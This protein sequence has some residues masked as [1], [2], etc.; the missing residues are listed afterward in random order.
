LKN[1]NLDMPS[2]TLWLLD[3]SRVPEEDVA[4]F[5]QQL[6]P[7]EVRRYGRF[8]RRQRKRQFLLGRMLLRF[9]ASNLISLPLDALAIIERESNAPQLVLPNVHYLQPA[10]SISHSR[11]WVACV[12]SPN[13]S[14][15]VDIEVN[16]PTRDVLGISQLVFHSDDH[17]WLLQQIDSV[18][19]SAFYHLWCTR[20]ALYKLMFVL[21][22]ETV[23]LPLVDGDGMLVSQGAGWYGYTLAH[24]DLTIAICSDHPL[25]ALRRMELAGFSRA[26]WLAQLAQQHYRIKASERAINSAISVFSF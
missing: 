22:R 2:A 26:D 13:A 14:L 10:F 18:R 24:F 7:S 19:L 4:F 21:G 12:V 11:D 16:D 3:G 6:G 25:S 1:N 5:V 8:K 15:G 23:S 9:A 17:R 20:E